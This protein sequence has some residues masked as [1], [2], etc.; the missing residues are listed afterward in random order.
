MCRRAALSATS[1]LRAASAVPGRPERVRRA[2]W[3]PP[4][5]ERDLAIALADIA[6]RPGR[7]A[8]DG[9]ASSQPA[10]ALAVEPSDAT[11]AASQA[12]T[13]SVSQTAGLRRP[14]GAGAW[15]QTHDDRVSQPAKPDA[16]A[17]EDDQREHVT[18]TDN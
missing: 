5:W 6:H 4:D 2:A 3:L 13:P 10:P 12:E 15:L 11:T 18:T 16:V 17:G 7:C 8:D 1:V 14:L 9:K